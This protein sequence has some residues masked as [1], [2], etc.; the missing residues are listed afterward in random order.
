V[1][2][3]FSRRSTLPKNPMTES[4]LQQEREYRIAER[5]GI[6]AGDQAPTR[7]QLKIAEEEAD[8]AVMMLAFEE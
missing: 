1:I 7:A 5:L 6:L 2:R 8:L 4:E 3:S